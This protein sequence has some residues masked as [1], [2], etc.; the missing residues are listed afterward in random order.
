[1]SDQSI[2][3]LNLEVLVTIGDANKNRIEVG[4]VVAF[5]ER[6]SQC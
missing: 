1:M 4:R 3:V 6:K 5:V 2:D